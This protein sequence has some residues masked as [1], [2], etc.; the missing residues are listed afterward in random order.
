MIDE[1]TGGAAGVA[2]AADPAAKSGDMKSW[3][4]SLAYAQDNWDV[5]MLYTVDNT[6]DN[7]YGTAGLKPVVAQVAAMRRAFAILLRPLW[8]SIPTARTARTPKPW[9][10]AASPLTRC[11]L[12]QLGSGLTGWTARKTLSAVWRRVI[13]STPTAKWTLATR[14]STRT[15]TRMRRTISAWCCDTTSNRSSRPFALPSEAE[16]KK[17]PAPKAGVFICLDNK[18]PRSPLRV[19]RPLPPPPAQNRGFFFSRALCDNADT[20]LSAIIS[21]LQS[22]N[23]LYLPCAHLHIPQYKKMPYF[24][25]NRDFLI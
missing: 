11:G 20:S 18:S 24:W 19:P 6:S 15:P 8:L 5:G 7:D 23:F 16:S 12:P 10:L 13:A 14:S 25:P 3:S 9:V 4:A 21:F 17:T 2:V 22:Y 1:E